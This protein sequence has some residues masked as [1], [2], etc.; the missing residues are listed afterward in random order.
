MNN[1]IRV[2]KVVFYS[3]DPTEQFIDCNENDQE[4]TIAAA[5]ASKDSVCRTA[6][7][8]CCNHHNIDF[9]TETEEILLAYLIKV[10]KNSWIQYSFF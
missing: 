1:A 5:C 2:T 6:S 9:Q 8:L 10:L 3:N 4:D 7:F